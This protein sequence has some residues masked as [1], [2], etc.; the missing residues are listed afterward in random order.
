MGESVV[1]AVW[2]FG[3]NVMVVVFANYELAQTPAYGAATP[4]EAVAG[5]QKAIQ[6][7]NVAGVLPFMSPS[8]RQ[9]LETTLKKNAI[10]ALPMMGSVSDYKI[11]GDK[12]T[13][14]EG[15]GTIDFERINGRWYLAPPPG[16]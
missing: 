11:S 15:T 9:F 12:A 13:A 6:A 14:K 1:R 4:Q 7:G 10:P 5:I 3:F 16:K 2:A 8:G